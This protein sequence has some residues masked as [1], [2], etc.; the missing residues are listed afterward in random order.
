MPDPKVQLQK[1][2]KRFGDAVILAALDLALEQGEFLTLL[3]PSGCGKTTTLRMIAG[4]VDPTAGRILMD[5]SDITRLPPNKREVGMVFQNYAL[6]PHLTVSQ[7]IA[8]GMKQRGATESQQRTRVHELLELVKLE[9][10]G[11]RY[12]AELSGGQRQRVAIARAVAHPPQILLMDEPLGALDLKLRESM[13][14]ELRAIQKRLK[15]TTLYVT[16]DQT[17]AMVMSD[18]IVVMNKGRVEQLGTAEDIYLRPVSRFVAEFVGRINFIPVSSV[19]GDSVARLMLGPAIVI[20]PDMP[21]ARSGT[22]HLLLAIRPEHLRIWDARDAAADLNI[23]DGK[24]VDRVFVGNLVNL[25]VNVHG[26]MVTVETRAAGQLPA[27]G[28]V[29]RLC[30]HP[31]EATLFENDA[32]SGLHAP[33][34]VDASRGTRVEKRIESEPKG[35]RPRVPTLTAGTR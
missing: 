16:H 28:Q 4:F 5:G 25:N 2:E 1:V 9:G 30:W 15:I 11:G 12:P 29:V 20:A 21:L 13:Q 3:G 24:V 35:T 34:A 27:P 23:V 10:T 7:N 33:P 17:E 19:P 18:R 32:G 6:F 26:V 14:Q 22:P 31:D 8:F